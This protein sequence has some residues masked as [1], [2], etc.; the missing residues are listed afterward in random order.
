MN[1]AGVVLLVVAGILIVVGLALSI[2]IVKQYGRGVVFR[3]GRLVGMS[4]P[5]TRICGSGTG[6]GRIARCGSLAT[7]ECLI[8]SLFVASEPSG[9]GF[10]NPAAVKPETGRDSAGAEQRISVIAA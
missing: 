1:T 9:H 4:R 2:R 3:L 5:R 10:A 8:W 6:C 7:N